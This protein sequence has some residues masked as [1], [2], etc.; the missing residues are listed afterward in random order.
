MKKVFIPLISIFLILIIASFGLYQWWVVNTSSVSNEKNPQSFVIAKGKSAMQI[1]NKLYE[2]GLIKNP[3][4]FKIYVQFFGKA[5]NINAGEFKLSPDMT[6]AEIINTLQG[7]PLE[8]WVTIPEGLRK[9]EV[10]EVIIDSL[11]K[12][13]TDAVNFRREFLALTKDKEGYLFPD[14][15]L[16]PPDVSAKAVVARL[17]QTFESKI[18]E[19][20]LSAIESSK[21]SLKDFVT[22]ASILERET[23]TGDERP[24]VAGILWKRLE[25]PGW[26]LQ[27]DA[28]VQYAIANSKLPE[29]LGNGADK[30]QNSKP[31]N[32][33]QTLTKEDL[34]I[35]SF[36]NSYKYKPLPPTPIANPGLSSLKAAIFPQDSDYWF[37]I[38]D[39]DAKIHYAKTIEDHNANISKYLGK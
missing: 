18:D 26:L 21:Y 9:E 11:E 5:K 12:E 24:I 23:A 33:W 15:Y 17:T 36:Y 20:M 34:E 14:T 38:H 30:T 19:D 31:D 2:Q 16:F 8:L 37:Y 27:A 28:T 4:A 1:G 29:K 32:W 25:T 22:M 6:L 3:L 35:D 13:N 7:G 10:V 39:D